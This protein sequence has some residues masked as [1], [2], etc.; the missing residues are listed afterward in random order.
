MKEFFGFDFHFVSKF[1]RLDSS[2]AS[3]FPLRGTYA[4][5]TKMSLSI[6]KC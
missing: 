1:S 5:D 4:A 3:T 6:Q 2:S